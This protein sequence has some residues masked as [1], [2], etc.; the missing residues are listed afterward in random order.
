MK[1]PQEETPHPHGLSADDSE[2]LRLL[3]ERIRELRAR[4]GMTRRILATDSG[5]SERFL[6][7]LETGQGN[8]S[9]VRLR[10]VAQAMGLPVDDLI[11]VGPEQPPDLTLLAQYLSRL[12]PMKL[13]RAR[14][15]LQTEFETKGKRDRIAL[16]GLRG[17]GKSTL[18][19]LLA[20]H[21]KVPFIEL[22]QAVET[23]AGITLSEI[24][25]LYGQAAYRRYERRTLQLAIDSRDAFILAPGGS[26][27]SEP[28]T[29]DV[30][31]TSCYTIWLKASPEEH[32]AR[33][34]AQGDR[35]PMDDNREAMKDLTRI[36]AGREAMYAKA[37]ASI[38]TS[39]RTIEQSFA[40]LLKVLPR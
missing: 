17:A 9:I 23:E 24:F 5:V 32:M 6:A 28:A 3:G 19:A 15:L 39:G 2:Y 20:Q 35:R 18:G 11:R 30:L 4:R 31:L 22:A 33:V 25:S 12:S 37:D 26:I 13:A 1:T 36:L 7:Q 16:I 14:E 10:Q 34:V 40:E 29:F 27:V 21:R 38:D 8:I